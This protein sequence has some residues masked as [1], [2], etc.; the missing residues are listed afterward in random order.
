MCR[1]TW[2]KV[3]GLKNVSWCDS[4]KRRSSVNTTAYVTPRL[5]QNGC[6][7]A[8][9][10]CQV[11][12]RTGVWHRGGR[13]VLSCRMWLCVCVC[14]SWGVSWRSGSRVASRMAVC[15]GVRPCDSDSSST[16]SCVEPRRRTKASSSCV[17]FSS[18]ASASAITCRRGKSVKLS[19]LNLSSLNYDITAS[20]A[21]FWVCGPF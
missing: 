14:T 7:R 8:H 18:A 9:T 3:E 11:I 21:F 19:G 12:N 2:M 20:F 13:W 17:W 5:L 4:R 10:Q 6:A 15:S 16:S 1:E